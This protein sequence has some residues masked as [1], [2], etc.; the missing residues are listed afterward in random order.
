MQSLYRTEDVSDGV[1]T[2]MPNCSTCDKKHELDSCPMFSSPYYMGIGGYKQFLSDI[3]E[4]NGCFHHPNAREYL[5]AD[6]IKEL[7]TL[8]TYPVNMKAAVYLSDVIAIIRDG[9]K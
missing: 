5:M 7:D 1:S 4:R 3:V 6:V 8:Q 2:M 9:V